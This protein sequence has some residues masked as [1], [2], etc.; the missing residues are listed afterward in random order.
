MTGA[1]PYMNLPMGRGRW[2][3]RGGRPTLAPDGQ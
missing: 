2:L 3:T 1:R